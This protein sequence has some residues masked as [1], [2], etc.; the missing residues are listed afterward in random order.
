[1][2]RRKLTPA[3]IIIVAAGAIML[4]GS[5]LTFYKSEANGVSVA[6]ANAWDQGLFLVA[7]LPA[8]L[9]VLMALQ[10]VLQVFGNITMPNRMLGL[11]WDQ[12]HVVVAFQ[13]ALLMVAFLV[14]ARLNEDWLAVASGACYPRS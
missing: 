10:I 6:E 14:R 3:D 12:F 5:F 2:N 4:I 8:L 11:T 9:G 7:T 1:M 13:A